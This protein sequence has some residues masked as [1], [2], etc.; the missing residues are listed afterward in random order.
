MI[1]SAIIR[2]GFEDGT[3]WG[4][5]PDKFAGAQVGTGDTARR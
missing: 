4:Y 1:I 2:I 3:I 5:T